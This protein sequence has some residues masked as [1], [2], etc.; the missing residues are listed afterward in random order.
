MNAELE[1]LYV[2]A[3]FVSAAFFGVPVAAAFLWKGTVSA[4]RG[5]A[6]IRRRK[7][8]GFLRLAFGGA[9]VAF[10]LLFLRWWAATYWPFLVAV[11]SSR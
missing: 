10:G 9:A 8:I 11:A 5:C 3:F 2:S 1:A 6:A 4:A 7:V